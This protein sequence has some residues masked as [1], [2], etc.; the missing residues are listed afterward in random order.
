MNFLRLLAI[1]A[2]LV[3]AAPVHAQV[4]VV[5]LHGKWGTP[6]GPTQP[7]EMAMRAAGFHVIARDM[8]WSDTRAYD[9]DL[10]ASMAEIDR[11]VAEL[12]AAGATRIVVAGQSLG[13][14]MALA[15][16]ARHPEL[17]GL[18]VVSPGHTPE[19]SFRNPRLA[20]SLKKAEAMIAAGKVDSYANFDDLN[21]GRE[22]EVS[23]KPG[24]YLS[25]FDPQGGAVM[26]RNAA[27]LSPHTALLWVV[28]THDQMYPEG[29]GYA[30]DRA[31][32]NPQSAYRTVEADHFGAPSAAREIVVDWLKSLR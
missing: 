21:Q 2:A 12:R 6:H 26:P 14:N 22:R 20:E 1:V 10:D 7:L 25:Y 29:T 23:A 13:G 11:Q 28:G 27:K 3:I 15:Y 8:A 5:L 32:R 4:G 24:V 18:V 30:F 16:G 19:R 17:D 9:E 31:P